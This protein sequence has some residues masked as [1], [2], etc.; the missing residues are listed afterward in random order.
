MT[1]TLGPR[2]TAGRKNRPGPVSPSKTL[3]LMEITSQS[4]TGMVMF[5]FICIF[6]RPS[7]QHRCHRYHSLDISSCLLSAICWWSETARLTESAVDIVRFLKS[8]EVKTGQPCPPLTF[9]TQLTTPT[10]R[11]VVQPF[12]ALPSF[13]ARWQLG[14]HSF[15]TTTSF[16]CCL[17]C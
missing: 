13:H 17:D 3:L 12:H 2:H 9:G 5:D 10:A 1:K 4:H 14:S 11:R 8:S 15:A 6:Y 7:R 16:T